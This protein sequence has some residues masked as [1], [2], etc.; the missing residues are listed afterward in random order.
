MRQ[1]FATE[2]DLNCL[3]EESAKGDDRL[4]YREDLLSTAIALCPRGQGPDTVCVGHD[5]LYWGSLIDDDVQFR[6]WESLDAGAIPV[7]VKHPVYNLL[8]KDN[9]IM[10]VDDMKVPL[11]SHASSMRGR[12]SFNSSRILRRW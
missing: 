7:V 8:P 11:P 9:P 2:N 10:W 4:R 6:L 5:R 1:D 3:I 12:C